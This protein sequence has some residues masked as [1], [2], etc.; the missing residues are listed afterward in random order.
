MRKLSETK[1]LPEGFKIE[2]SK[3]QPVG[4]KMFIGGLSADISKQALREY[5]SQFGEVVDFIIKTHPNTGLPRGFGFVLFKDKAT[6]EKVLQIQEHIV[7]GRK[8]ELKRAKVM[9][10]K[11]CPR[12]VFVGGLNPRMPEE[13]IREYFGTF[14]VIENIEL[15]VS[16]RTNERRAFCFISYAEETA[17]RKLLEAKYHFIGSG[18]CEVK[19]ALRNPN[20]KPQQMGERDAPLPSVGNPW[21][22]RA[23]PANPNAFTAD[24]NVCGAV[25]G[26]ESSSTMLVPVPLAACN[27]GF[28]FPDE[29]YGD[30]YN[31]YSDQPVFHNYS[32]QYFLGYNHGTHAI[33]AVPP[34]YNVQMNE[35][36]PFDPGCHGV[37]QLF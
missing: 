19:I 25:G 7:C 30:F 5:L 12:K 13:K 3:N 32:G 35:A 16:R 28:V 1:D 36:A 31:V 11:F 21:G 15:P 37:Y 10:S 20:L 14:G 18:R 17:V 8:I 9:E 29:E 34:N 23:L 22:D 6:V 27:Q 26:G 33:G 24:Q 4:N 2:V